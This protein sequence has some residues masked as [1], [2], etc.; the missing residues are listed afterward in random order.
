MSDPMGLSLHVGVNRVDP[1]HYQGW[2][3]ALQGCE[4]DAVAMAAIAAVQGF[5]HRTLLTADATADAVVAG[6]AEA[7]A[8]LRPGDL[9]VLTYAGHGSQVPD[10]NGDEDDALDETWV[11][12]DRQLVDDELYALWGRFR[13][14][15][16]ILVVS[17]S[18]HSGSAVRA[19]LGGLRPEILAATVSNPSEHGMRAMPRAVRAPVY[20]ANRDVYDGIQASCPSGDAV[21]VGAHVLLLSGC[22]DA[23][24]SADGE[25][26]GLFTQT[27]LSV[28]QDGAFQL[29]HHRFW[30]DIVAAMPFWQQPNYFPVGP[31]VPWI[32]QG[33]PFTI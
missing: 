30:K 13:P 18:C 19:V 25:R 16:R 23:Q 28:W 31:S 14:G 32:N 24:T 12:Y 27:L 33:R 6:I 1:A 15:V 9:F 8:R 7:A 5:E 11:L 21:D 4:P 20:E 10:T 3:G 17:D 26:N 29:G 22:Q 2:D